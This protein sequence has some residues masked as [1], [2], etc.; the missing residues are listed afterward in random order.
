M[1][2]SC[3]EAARGALF[4]A[5]FESVRLGSPSLEPEHLLLALIREPR[6]HTKKLLLQLPLANIREQVENRHSGE[7]LDSR[8]EILF[9]ASAK[10]VLS[11]AFDEADRLGH[12][13]VRPEH[14]LLG[15]L[16]DGDSLAATVLARHGMQLEDAR[17]KVRE[18]YMKESAHQSPVHAQLDYVMQSAQ[19]VQV[20]LGKENVNNDLVMLQAGILMVALDSLK[21]LLEQQ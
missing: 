14:L 20:L 6:A 18:S 2:E 13:C 4:F 17:E 15:I 3:D 16:R 12:R 1:F 8:G 9:S 7:R 10:R 5:R 21:S 19:Q 11:C